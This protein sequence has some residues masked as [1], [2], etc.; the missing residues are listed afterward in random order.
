MNQA[1]RRSAA[2]ALGIALAASLCAD[3]EAAAS[4]KPHCDHVARDY[5]NQQSA[6]SAA[7]GAVVGGML[8]GGIGGLVGGAAGGAAGSA[9][10]DAAYQQRFDYC[11]Q[12]N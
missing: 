9:Q 6:G 10:W 3:A 5:A 12:G 8:G 4:R 1:A 2:G 7:A 11:M